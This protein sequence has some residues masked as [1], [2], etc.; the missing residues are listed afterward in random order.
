MFY[1]GSQNILLYNFIINTFDCQ[2]GSQGGDIS[3]RAFALARFGFGAATAGA[4]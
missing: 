4:P 3:A 2:G 1:N